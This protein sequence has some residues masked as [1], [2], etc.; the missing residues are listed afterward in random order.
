M[1][2]P[3]VYIV[4]AGPG[5]PSL[6]TVRGRRYLQA[7]DVVVYDHRVHPRL[8]QLAKPGAE[9]IDVGSAAP[10]PQEQDAISYLL[11]EKAREGRTVVRLKWGDPFIFDSG[12]K[13]ALFLHEQG[14]P[15]EV[16]PG[17]PAALGGAAYAGVPLT[18][19]GAGDALTFVRGHEGEVDA[20]PDVDWDRLAGLGGTIACYAGS[21]QIGAIAEKLIAHGRPPEET[22]ALIYDG[23]LPSQQTLEGTL[24][25]IASHARDGSAALLI[26]GAVAGLR[27]HLRWFDE[28][29]LFGK[30][31]VVTRSLEQ[32]GELIEMLE[33]RGAEAIPASAIRIAPPEDPTPLD[34]ACAEAGRYDWIVF[35]SGNAVDSFMDR[36]LA[37]S[38]IRELKGVKICTIGPTT[39][40]RV[41]RYGIKVDLTPPEFRAEAV[42]DALKG[43]GSLRGKRFLLPRA[44]IARDLLAEELSQAGADVHD[45][46]AYRTIPASVDREGGP[47]IYRMLLDRQIDAVT[48]TSASTVRNFVAML[49]M[50]QAVDLLRTTVVASIGPV[51]A[52][53]AQQLDIATSVMPARYTI[54]DLV[55]SLVEHFTKVEVVETVE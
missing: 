12:G 42:V 32:A 38:D 9:R 23:S 31:I 5:D 47:D 17:I 2:T 37:R 48:F 6:L 36:L 39:A 11:A 44:D 20:P 3:C 55:D 49:G 4:G 54:P 21:R 8:L 50:D 46:I 19:P 26:V 15:F 13:E 41:A 16:V 52:E 7:A 35:T 10:K 29:P 51:T 25:T 1:N 33:E 24:A 53:A 40:S 14:I 18:Y 34:Q 43:T 45:V 27:Q 30:R 22:A 28:R